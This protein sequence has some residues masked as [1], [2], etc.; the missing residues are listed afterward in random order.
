MPSAVACRCGQR[1]LAQ[2]F[3]AGKQVPCP[4]CGASIQVP[5]S[6]LAAAAVASQASPSETSIKVKCICG[7]AYA[8][9]PSMQGK[10][11]RCPTCGSSI[12][13]PNPSAVAELDE[14][15]VL[16]VDPLAAKPL[17]VN[18]PTAVPHPLRPPAAAGISPAAIVALVA[19]A[20]LLLLLPLIGLAFFWSSD[21]TVAVRSPEI[22]RDISP[23]TVAATTAPGPPGPPPA[24][25]A[26]G[27]PG[28]PAISPTV[29]PA[30]AVPE[31]QSV[32]PSS[33]PVD[34][35]ELPPATRSFA[36]LRGSGELAP[37]LQQW[38]AAGKAPFKGV[39]RVGPGDNLQAHYSW[40]VQVLP[41]IG[42]Q[43][44]YDKFDF[45]QSLLARD[46]LQLSGEIIPEFQNPSDNRR[47]WKGYP[48]EDMA[49]THFVGMAGVE[50]SRNVVAARLP[51]SD[52]RAGIFGYDEVARP[53][54]ITDGL[55]QTIMVI[56]GGELASP[57]VMG[58]GATV[59]GARE[60]YFDPLSGFGSRG[61]ATAGAVVVMADGSV[62]QIS[63]N[64]DP[65]V[66]RS[67]CTI[68]G[69]EQFDLDS[70]APVTTMHK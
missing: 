15:D 28:P 39:N 35:I 49:L 32:E 34:K 56:G 66:F 9:K 69:R 40:L 68:H 30:P 51:R 47:R 11:L 65:Q 17:P 16:A 1:F 42:H 10:S 37:G 25:S 22:P 63:A 52:P 3:L 62:R 24:A 5:A 53:A 58:G 44:I 12:F 33:A 21:S 64:I 59:R 45:Q 67:M 4:A 54:E 26:P 23:S 48:F 2:D 46:N 7:Q 13:V 41:Y 57:W 29:A 31:T 60:P 6:A 50:D 61:R 38:F 14:V 20:A 55:S 8:A 27:P 36:G 19:G 18:L 70:A 43:Q